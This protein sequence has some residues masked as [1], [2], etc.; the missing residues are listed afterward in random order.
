LR[1]KTYGTTGL[2]GFAMAYIEQ[3]VSDPLLAQWIRD[4]HEESEA[5]SGEEVGL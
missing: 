1:F 5:L 3:A 4:A 2:S